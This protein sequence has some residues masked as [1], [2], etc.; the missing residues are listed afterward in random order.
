MTLV[1]AELGVPA[2]PALAE[3]VRRAGGN[4]LWVVELVPLPEASE[5]APRA[6]GVAVELLRR[7]EALLPAAHPERDAVLAEIVESLLR[8]GHV[9]QAG[10]DMA[11]VLVEADDLQAAFAGLGSSQDPFDVWFR[12]QVREVHGMNLED[13][14]PPPEQILDFRAGDKTSGDASHAPAEAIG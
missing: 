13:G 11:V 10:G 14:F 5:A 7:A 4:P 12:E 2:G 9:S 3:A 1:H 6:P 8:T